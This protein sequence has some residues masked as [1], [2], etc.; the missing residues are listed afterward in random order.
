MQ[1]TMSNLVRTAGRVMAAGAV[2]ATAMLGGHITGAGVAPAEAASSYTLT[3][4]PPAG[5]ALAW[6]VAPYS[7]GVCGTTDSGQRTDCTIRGSMMTRV[8]LTAQPTTGFQ[9]QNWTG[10]CTGATGSASSNGAACSIL[11]LGNTTTSATFTTRMHILT[12]APSGY[13]GIVAR[14]PQGEMVAACFAWNGTCSVQVPYGSMLQLTPNADSVVKS[15]GS[16]CSV[17]DHGVCILTVTGNVTESAI[18]EGH[19]VKGGNLA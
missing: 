17:N 8:T 2:A 16:A 19:A 1:F 4:T 9:F 3:L 14:T 7:S 13:G 10:G 12:L 5:G 11:L 6:Q 18:V 15:W